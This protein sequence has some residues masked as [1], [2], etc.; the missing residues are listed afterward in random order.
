MNTKEFGQ[1]NAFGFNFVVQI[2]II[3]ILAL[4]RVLTTKWYAHL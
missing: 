2:P 4:M 3:E 1:D